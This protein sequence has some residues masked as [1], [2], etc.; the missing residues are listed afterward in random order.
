[1]TELIRNPEVMKKAQE[2]VRR[3][4]GD[5][6]VVE[7]SDLPKLKY[8]KLVTK[9]AMR[10]HPPAPF[11]VPRET[12]QNCT[13]KGYHV[14]AKTRV[15]V[16]AKAIGMDPKIWENPS[17][18]QPERFLYN[19]IDVKGQDFELIP[20]GVGRRGCP[21]VNFSVV[22][23]ELTQANF[24]HRVNW[25]LPSGMKPEEVDIDEA[26]GLTMHKKI[27]L[28]LLAQNATACKFA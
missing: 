15:F 16:A 3:S 21:S 18:F 23:V 5:K 12:T 2:D 19:D 13:I 1:M 8:L 20:F 22:L 14:P 28:C 11:L 7:E 9:E 27:P 10:H 4:V 25:K 17:A 26:D 6:E 24:L